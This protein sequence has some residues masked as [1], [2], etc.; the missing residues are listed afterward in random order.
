MQPPPSDAALRE[1][2][3]YLVQRFDEHLDEHT[4]DLKEALRSARRAPYDRLL[5][6]ATLLMSLASVVSVIATHH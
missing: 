1:Q 3:A 6:F 5:L 4:A 2:V